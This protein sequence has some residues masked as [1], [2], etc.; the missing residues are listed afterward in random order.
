V[1]WRG[2][3]S[4]K[5]GYTVGRPPGRRTFFQ[6]RQ[7]AKMQDVGLDY[8]ARVPENWTRASSSNTRIQLPRQM[9][10]EVVILLPVMIVS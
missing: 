10:L 3:R 5:S 2:R 7:A 6:K 4:N 9:L 8:V 1:E